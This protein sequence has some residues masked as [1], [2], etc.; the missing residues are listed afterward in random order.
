MRKTMVVIFIFI[1]SL[2]VHARV[3]FFAYGDGKSCKIWRK[4]AAKANVDIYC[5]AGNPYESSA[6]LKILSRETPDIIVFP[7]K[8]ELLF[9][10]RAFTGSVIDLHLLDTSFPKDSFCY[11]VADEICLGVWSG[12]K[13]KKASLKAIKIIKKTIR[14]HKSWKKLLEKNLRKYSVDGWWLYQ[15]DRS[16]KLL[17]KVTYIKSPIGYVKARIIRFKEGK[18]PAKVFIVE[19]PKKTKALSTLIG[20]A[21]VKAVGNY[22]LYPALWDKCVNIKRLKERLARRIGIKPKRVALLFTGA[23]MDNIAFHTERY[24]DLVVWVASTAGV[25]GN[26]MR[27]GVDKGY[28]LETENGWER[29][30][31]IN[32]L[33]F[34]NKKLTEGALASA[35]I[36]ATEA[37]TAV[38]QELGVRSTYTPG[39]IATGTGTDNI[40]VVSGYRGKFTSAGGHTLLGYMIAKAVREA[41]VT[42]VCLQS[43]ICK[44]L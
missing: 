8:L 36:R 22:Y 26:A 15:L 31:T 17:R 19:L 23:D 29:I 44:P 16:R 18:Y 12:S 33:I 2:N 24:K 27:A 32:I 39:V 5:Y 35:I 43:G 30:G 21:K 14:K 9:G 40:I 7:K 41:V 6:S 13:G 34:V 11:K 37:K 10:K 42:A 1:F 4:V 20:V 3:K 25:L 38:L 28:W